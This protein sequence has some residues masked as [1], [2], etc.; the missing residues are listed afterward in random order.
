LFCKHATASKK[1][2][3]YSIEEDQRA[4]LILH[5]RTHARTHTHTTHTHKQR[6]RHAAACYSIEE[7]QRALLKGYGSEVW[8]LFRRVKV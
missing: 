4:P 1:E 6:L 5:T 8:A 2:A 3:R 7:D